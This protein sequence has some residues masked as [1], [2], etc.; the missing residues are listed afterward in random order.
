LLGNNLTSEVLPDWETLWGDLVMLR[1]LGVM[2]YRGSHLGPRE[3]FLRC[4]SLLAILEFLDTL[5]MLGEVICK[6]VGDLMM[7]SLSSLSFLDSA[8]SVCTTI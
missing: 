4:N 2:G 6:L 3:I 8:S 5:N 1:V 7:P